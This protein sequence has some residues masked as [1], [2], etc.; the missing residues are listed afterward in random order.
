VTLSPARLQ[1]TV[2]H[3]TAEEGAAAEPF[4]GDLRT[5]RP[6]QLAEEERPR[7]SISA[8]SAESVLSLYIPATFPLGSVTVELKGATGSASVLLVVLANP[9]SEVDDVYLAEP[10]HR[11]EYVEK[12]EGLLFKGFPF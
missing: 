8:A 6:D 12:E 11:A 1:V 3:K 2:A 9:W 4:P 10:A 5:R 7:W